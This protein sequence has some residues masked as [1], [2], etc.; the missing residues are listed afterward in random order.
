[1][2]A[3]TPLRLGILVLVVTILA[4]AE[5][6]F[7]Q[8][9][10]T[11]ETPWRVARNFGLMILGTIAAKLIVPISTLALALQ[12]EQSKI[13]LLHLV[14]W[15]FAVE[16]AIS[17]VILDMAMYW[18]HVASHHVPML[19]KLHSVHHNDAELDFSSGIRFHPGEIL[20]S[21]AFKMIIITL[22]GASVWSVLAF[23]ILLNTS[24]LVTHARFALPNRVDRAL[25]WILVTPA[26]HV[27]HHSQR[28][29]ETNT[30]YG[31]FLAI[32]D[33]IFR[34]YTDD[35]AEGFKIGL[36]ETAAKMPHE[37]LWRLLIWPF[38]GRTISEVVPKSSS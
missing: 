8:R 36:E 15:P 21:L 14:A 27:I 3:E 13:G 22:L 17:L 25:R 34:T 6:C 12:L 26:M 7:P 24:A 35:A 16:L 31:F 5:F 28:P 18:Q 9:P 38:W 2:A 10:A 23:E 30:N 20:F 1:M 11:P 29:I 37:R 32:W 4:I 33:R 19:W